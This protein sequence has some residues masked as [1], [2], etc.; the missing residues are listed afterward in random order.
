GNLVVDNTGATP[1]SGAITGTGSV[2][3]NG[4]GTLTLSGNNGYGDT[5]FNAGV[6]SVEQ[7]ENLGIGALNFDGG[8]LQITGTHFNDTTKTIVWGDHGGGFDIADADNQ[9]ALSNVFTG[10]G[11]LAKKGA[12]TLAL[13]GDS[14]AFQ[15]NTLV[16]D[17][18]LR[19]DGGKLG[20]GTGTV[21]VASGAALGG[22]GSIGGNTTVEGTLF[23]Q[24]GQVL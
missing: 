8:T 19:L 12:G 17:G 16:K 1:L 3:Q 23:A 21:D 6:V 24:S 5:F 4:A 11:Q 9:F 20:D 14:S 18:T 7:E 13:T 2:T 10:L 22:H 15:G